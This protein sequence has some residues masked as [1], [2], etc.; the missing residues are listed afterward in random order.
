MIYIKKT[1][2][3]SIKVTTLSTWCMLGF[4]PALGGGGK[5]KVIPCQNT[6]HFQA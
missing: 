6:K 2:Y 3:L 5:A 1:K 4:V